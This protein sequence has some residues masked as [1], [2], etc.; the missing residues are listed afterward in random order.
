M[1]EIFL[2]S[3][4]T[5]D[6]HSIEDEGDG[7]HLGVGEAEEALLLAPP[8]VLLPERKL[9]VIMIVVAFRVYVYKENPG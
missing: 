8:Q 7:A 9:G 3:V 4:C 1:S 2:Y 5:P 6:G